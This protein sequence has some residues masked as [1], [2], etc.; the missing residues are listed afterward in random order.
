MP[1]TLTE[2]KEALALIANELAAVRDWVEIPDETEAGINGVL[3]SL[4]TLID[5]K[6]QKEL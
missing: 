3:D 2:M 1:T 6:E 4:N 5:T